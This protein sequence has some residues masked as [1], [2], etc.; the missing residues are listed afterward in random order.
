MKSEM[1]RDYSLHASLRHTSYHTFS[2]PLGGKR[3][4]SG[5]VHALFGESQLRVNQFFD[6]FIPNTSTSG[7]SSKITLFDQCSMNPSPKAKWSVR[8]RENK[9]FEI[10]FRKKAKLIGKNAHEMEM[11]K[12]ELDIFVNPGKPVPIFSTHTLKWI[13]DNLPSLSVLP[14]QACIKEF[15]QV[16]RGNAREFTH[17]L[18]FPKAL[19]HLPLVNSLT[20]SLFCF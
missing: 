15:I 10:K 12:K 20:E 16:K 5:F 3:P 19:S 6:F 7:W 4:T 11:E 9:C 13:F 18:F 2:P 1:S 17:I 8:N 14:W